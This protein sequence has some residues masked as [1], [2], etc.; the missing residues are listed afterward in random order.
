[1]IKT[2]P[3]FHYWNIILDFDILV[4]IFI[5]AYRIRHFALYVQSLEALAPWFFA[6]DRTNYARWIPVHIEDMKNLP[7]NIK[8]SFE[9]FWVIN[10]TNNKFSCMPIDEAH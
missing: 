10:K 8:K 2:S 1:M 7:E 3:T 4:L 9:K 5:R 6:L